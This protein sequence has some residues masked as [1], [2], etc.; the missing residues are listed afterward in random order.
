MKVIIIPDSFK[1]S[2]TASQAAKAM[3]E[4]LCEYDPSITTV[5]L[6]GADG[7]EGTMKSLVE[8]TDGHTKSVL[9]LDP[10]GRKREAE[11][12]VLGDGETCVIELA[13]ASGLL[14]LSETERNPLMT[15]SF[16]TGELILDALDAGFRK[17]IIGLGGSATND[18]GM[19][20]LRALGMK[21]RNKEG[22]EIPGGG[23][24]LSE[25]MEIDSTEFD[26]RI[27]TSE[28]IIACD[29][30]NPFVGPDG[31]SAV[32]GPQ[33]GATPEMVET[34]DGNLRKFANLVKDCT[35]ISLHNKKGAGA[36]GGAG[37]A[38]QAFFQGQMKQGIEVVLDAISF[39]KHIQNADLILTG[40]G[41]TDI[42]TLSGKTP[43]GIAK[44]AKEKEIPVIL[45]SGTL[46][47]SC[48]KD[49]SHIFTE[50]HSITDEQ[51][52]SEESMNDAY[53]LLRMKTWYV[54]EEYFK[55]K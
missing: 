26:K 41:K 29:V 10:L 15:T 2:L 50:L 32:F 18:G 28:F 12:G 11:Y 5:L 7:G 16:G 31:A 24:A 53:R 14:L 51:I 23:G 34:L 22:F 42:Q 44:V 1:G 6:S 48:K 49:L 9:V 21:F 4:G 54:M 38:F 13:E 47:K 43:F 39:E 55:G 3:A 45:I 20:M 25:L 36:A 46:E 17:F 35:G 30:E 8:A 27:L 19:G 37:G 40:E 52:S 33:K